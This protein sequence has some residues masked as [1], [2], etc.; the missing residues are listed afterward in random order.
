MGGP[1]DALSA[2]GHVTVIERFLPFF[3]R[4]LTD[5]RFLVGDNCAVNKR[6]ARL[7]G[8]PLAGCAT[9]A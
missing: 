2:D 3:G 5:V 1:D 8:I 6:L 4:S 9:I 7:M